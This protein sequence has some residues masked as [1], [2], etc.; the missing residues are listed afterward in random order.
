MAMRK[1]GL[2]G[3]GEIWRMACRMRVDGPQTDHGGGKS[4][5]FRHYFSLKQGLFLETPAA[6][7]S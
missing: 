7:S 3:I 5:F 2:T 1:E 6:L 4:D